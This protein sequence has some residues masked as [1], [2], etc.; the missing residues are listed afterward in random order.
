MNAMQHTGEYVRP[1]ILPQGSGI[2]HI[3]AARHPCVELMDN[4][5]FIAND[6]NFVRNESSFQIITG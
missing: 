6:Y 1:K 2:I 4:V 5:E 3:K